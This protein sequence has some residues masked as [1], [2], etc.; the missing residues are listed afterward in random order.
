MNRF[1][2]K[3]NMSSFTHTTCSVTPPTADSTSTASI[4]SLAVAARG[5][6]CSGVEEGTS[7]LSNDVAKGPI[8][9]L[10]CAAEVE[11]VGAKE[12][13]ASEAF[14]DAAFAVNSFA[15]AAVSGTPLACTASTN[16]SADKKPA[17][18]SVC[19]GSSF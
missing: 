13:S 11:H 10:A 16:A 6:A 8:A 7:A 15:D 12:E 17:V 5:L 18:V 14:D 3:V 9:A 4:E 2:D 19:G 1:G